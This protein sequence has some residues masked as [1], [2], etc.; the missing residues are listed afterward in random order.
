MLNA[1]GIV[2]SLLFPSL[3]GGYCHEAEWTVAPSRHKLAWYG[4]HGVLF[5][6]LVAIGQ[7][8][9]AVSS[10]LRQDGELDRIYSCYQIM[11][12]ATPESHGNINQMHFIIPRSTRLL[13]KFQSIN[14]LWFL[15][16]LT[17]YIHVNLRRDRYAKFYYE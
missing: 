8:T 16:F 12:P 4:R 17:E 7:V 13:K 2:Q 14:K 1:S 9:W 15:L 10:C 6:S 11:F 3:A 5:L